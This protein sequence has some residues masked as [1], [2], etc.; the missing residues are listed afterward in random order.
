MS[1]SAL[2]LLDTFHQRPM[3]L[4]VSDVDGVSQADSP[5]VV[6]LIISRIAAR[7]KLPLHIRR[8]FG[9]YVACRHHG[10]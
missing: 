10:L 2:F 1:L 7:V 4:A 3:D 5:S 9:R 8:S 6:Y